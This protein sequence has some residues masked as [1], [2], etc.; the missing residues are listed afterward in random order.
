MSGPILV[1]GGTGQLATCL[2]EQG[3]DVLR[4]GRPDFDFDAPEAIVPL[5]ARLRPRLVV[6]AAAYTAVDKAESE[7]AAAARANETGPGLIA[8]WCAAAGV[9]LIHVSTDY[10]F[11]GAKGAPYVETDA[12]NPIG[13]Y[14]ASKRAG[15]TAVLARHPQAVILR[16]S[17]VYAAQGKNFVRTML[18][19]ARKTD[20][21]RV[22]ADQIGCPTDAHDLAAAI[23]AIAARLDAEGMRPAFAGITHAAGS[24]WTSWHGLAHEIFTAAAPLGLRMPTVEPIATS[25]WPT[26]VR[27]PADSRLDCSRLATVFGL[28]LPDWQISLHRTVARILRDDSSHRPPPAP[29]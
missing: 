10:V 18:G 25:D 19:A 3:P 4:V 17:W 15:E 5:L 7:P 13:V 27:R 28:R 22:V 21:L 11:D 29:G 2:A 16:T 9:P 20:R 1:T 14:G 8:G 26:P 23:L 12:P 6:N 24:G